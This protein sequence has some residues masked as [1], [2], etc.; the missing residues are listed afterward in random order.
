MKRRKKITGTNELFTLCFTET[1]QSFTIYFD[2]ISLEYIEFFLLQRKVCLWSYTWIW[3]YLF[4]ALHYSTHD[5]HTAYVSSN[6]T[7]I[8]QKHVD[9]W[10]FLKK[11]VFTP[12]P[13]QTHLV[14][15]SISKR[16]DLIDSQLSSL[17]HWSGDHFSSS[18]WEKHH[19]LNL[20]YTSIIIFMNFESWLVSKTKIMFTKKHTHTH[21]LLFRTFSGAKKSH[22]IAVNCNASNPLNEQFIRKLNSER[23]LFIAS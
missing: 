4:L 1:N 17:Y 8:H 15:H 14:L 3:Q 20:L 11:K 23:K 13:L 9:I 10:F 21:T 6:F 18:W 2:Y 12:S 7:L 16:I 22:Y 19:A 5:M